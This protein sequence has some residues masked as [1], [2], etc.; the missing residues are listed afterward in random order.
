[1]KNPVR[2]P[3]L[4]EAIMKRRHTLPTAL[5]AAGVALLAAAGVAAGAQST[6]Q[7]PT[8]HQVRQGGTLVAELS[9]D[10][11]YVDPGLDYMSQGWEIQY[12]TGCKLLNYPDTNGTGGSQLAPEV[13]AGLPRVSNSGRTYTFTIRKGFRFADGAPVTAQSFADAFN[14]DASPKLQSPAQSF[15]TDIVGANAVMSGSSQRISGVVAS[16]QTLAIT[17]TKPAPDLLT[18]VAM[19]FFQAVPKGVAQSVDQ[20]GV[21]TIKSC[22][23]YYVADRVPGK[24]ITLNRNPFYGGSRPHNLTQI[25]YQVG[26]SPATIQQNVETGASDYAHEVRV[27]DINTVGTIKGGSG[28]FQLFG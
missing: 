1:M 9:T 5:V 15:M 4:R 6:A 10:V 27:D 20:S 12:A 11:D 14:R 13:A 19:P 16:G 25:T 22:G 26:N 18:R 2:P 7:S 23:P 3:E 21:N 17:L 28:A 24:S 8:T